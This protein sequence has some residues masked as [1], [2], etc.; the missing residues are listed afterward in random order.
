MF[1]IFHGLFTLFAIG[2]DNTNKSIQDDTNKQQAI[3]NG[4]LTYQG[5]R[6]NEY[7]VENDRW[8]ST[9][10]VNGHDVIADMKTGQIYYDITEIKKKNIIDECI[11][12]GKTVR[13]KMP[14]ERLSNYYGKYKQSF[15]Y[16][17]IK[18]DIPVNIVYINGACFYIRVDNGDI[19][20]LIDGEDKSRIIGKWSVEQIINIINKRQNIIRNSITDED[21]IKIGEE[22]FFENNKVYVDNNQNIHIIWNRNIKKLHD[23]YH[24]DG[25]KYDKE[26]KRW[27]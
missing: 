24:K 5:S 27:I 2:V 9:K 12:K 18:T 14:H 13:S 26:S 23:L 1:S 16:V 15:M 17:D 19:L 10:R 4:Q 8:V 20:R 21:N 7:L 22:L 3:Q 25:Y 6:G 11:K